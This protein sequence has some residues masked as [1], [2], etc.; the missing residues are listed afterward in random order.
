MT[1]EGEK[2]MRFSVIVPVY[3]SEKYLDRC[4]KSILGQSCGDFELLLI[5][6]GSTD[7]SKAICERYSESD[8]RV[9]L[10]CQQ[11]KGPS[12]ARN[13]GLRAASGEY[14]VF[15]DSDEFVDVDYFETLDKHIQQNRCDLIFIGFVMELEQNGKELETVSMPSGIYSKDEFH[16]IVK[17]LIDND[18]FGYQVVKAVK[19]SLIKKYNIY[20]DE[21]VSLHEDMLFTCELCKFAVSIEVVDCTP[22]H[23]RKGIEGLCLKYREDMFDL[24]DYLNRKYFDFFESIS[25]DDVDKMIV[26]RG[27]FSF[28]LIMKNE[29]NSPRLFSKE[30]LGEYDK[31]LNGYTCSEIR[32]RKEFY[33]VAVSGKKKWIVYAVVFSK[34]PYLFAVM[35][36]IY[37]KLGVKL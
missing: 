36:W 4:V 1:Y 26:Q 33:N 14:V 18:Q 10:I 20:L 23:Y 8:S 13:N 16:S 19:S 31:F 32:K 28:F 29:V 15:I 9:R 27:V 25:I 24:M 34:N 7:G 3:N 5:D 21:S 35:L 12:A 37:K 11:N 6:D 30:A 22:Y 2:N 17:K